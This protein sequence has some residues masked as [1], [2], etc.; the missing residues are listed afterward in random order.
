MISWPHV[1]GQP[2]FFK[3]NAYQQKST[4]HNIIILLCVSKYLGKRVFCKYEATRIYNHNYDQTFINSFKGIH[5]QTFKIDLYLKINVSAKYLARWNTG[6]RCVLWIRFFCYHNN[7]IMFAAIRV[8]NLAIMIII[9]ILL[10]LS[11][12]SLAK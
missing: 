7:N 1:H 4:W 10:S 12:T 9:I 3:V 5:A 8:I 2:L 11:C 6:I